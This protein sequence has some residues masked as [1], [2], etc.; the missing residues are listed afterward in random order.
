LFPSKS[1]YMLHTV[2]HPGVIS[3]CP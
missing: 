2:E 1:G 3:T